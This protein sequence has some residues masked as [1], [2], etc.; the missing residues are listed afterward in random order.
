MKR[1]K[2]SRQSAAAKRQQEIHHVFQRIFSAAC[3]LSADGV[4]MWAIQESALRGMTLSQDRRKAAAAQLSVKRRFE[5]NK[6]MLE[7]IVRLS[8]NGKR[9]LTISEVLDDCADVEPPY[10]RRT[11]KDELDFFGLYKREKPG[12]QRKR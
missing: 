10:D 9:S 8:G 7:A 3:L 5:R 6:P 1:P 4:D 2:T 11:V 12:P